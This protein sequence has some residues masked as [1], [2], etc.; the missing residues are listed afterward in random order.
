MRLLN[1]YL[2]AIAVITLL[3]SSCTQE[4]NI[5]VNDEAVSPDV[6]MLYLGPVLNDQ[7]GRQQEQEI[8][9]CSE[10]TPAFAQIRLT[11][12]DANTPIELVVPILED[13]EGLFTAYDE[14]LEIPVTSGNSVSVTLTDF[15]VWSDENE[16]GTPDE[17]IW[18]APK[19]GSDFAQFVSDPLDIVWELR[20]GSKN[21]QEVEVICFDDRDVNLYGYQFFDITPVPLYELCVFANYCTDAG[22]H[23]T[24]NYELDLYTYS[25]MEAEEN[26]ITD[27][28]LYTNIYMGETPETGNDDGSFYAD[29]L[30]LAIP[31]PA[32]G[33]GAS[34]PYLYY[35]IRLNDWEGYY[36][37]EPMVKSGYLT[38]N[39]IS[40]WLTVEG[41]DD[42]STV[43]Y[44]HV[45]FNCADDDGPEPCDLDDPDAD[46]DG[47]GIPNGEDECPQE[48]PTVDED[49]DG[50]EDVTQCDQSDPEADCDNDGTLN[51]CDEDNPNYGTFDCDGDGVINS[52]DDCPEFAPTVDEDGD[53]CEDVS[54][55]DETDP[56]ADCDGDGVLNKCDEDNPNYGT[57]D[58]D[59]DGVINSEDDCP[60]VAPTV[61]EDGDGC[62]DVAQ[63]DEN[64]PEADCD[65]DGT[66]N[67]CDEDNPNY[68][69]FDCDGDG[70][71]NGNDSCPNDAASTDLDGDGC[72]DEL[73]PCLPAPDSTLSC[74]TAT[75][76][77]D[78]S[79]NFPQE[80]FLNGE[81][82]GDLTFDINNDGNV[83]LG[84]ALTVTGGY[85]ID[86]VEVAIGNE[87][88][89]FDET[90]YPGTATYLIDGTSDFSYP[91]NDVSVR[92]NV[93]PATE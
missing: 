75:F 89:C 58:C 19:E 92:L 52:E 41:D 28:A 33:Q 65:N 48:N 8:P 22:R 69:T 15:L 66:L 35:E 67:K 91:L 36:D 38:W 93:C 50:C 39:Q 2:A 79:N 86:E 14:A 16:D 7:L 73:E 45:F 90:E 21:Y 64:D 26:P 23:F 5:Q 47:D 76:T 29:P 32:E 84:V 18:A 34:T 81:K 1:K 51:K 54:Q 25:G 27:S 77:G 30:C 56:D 87:I 71:L 78:V 63:C 44:W 6:A 62:E 57:F 46:C 80:I 61:D 13:D 70:V 11:F 4:E 60:E 40:D 74:E 68:A 3:F 12:G 20:A 31:G 10:A 42:N 49:G 88:S 82:I 83:E 72:E 53:G 9:D 85:L 59:G 43:D 17:V 37:A 55:C 24:A